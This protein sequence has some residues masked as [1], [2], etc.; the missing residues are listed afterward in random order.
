MGKVLIVWKYI[1]MFINWVGKSFLG[2]DGRVSS[3]RLLAFSVFMGCYLSGRIVFIVKCD[4]WLYQLYAL[5]LD[6]VFIL[7][8]FGIVHASDVAFLKTG[9]KSEK[10]ENK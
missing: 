8:L 7:M 3:R 5:A 6:A 4:N 10:D 9:I 1:F 2:A